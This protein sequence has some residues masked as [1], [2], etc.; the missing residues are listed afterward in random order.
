MNVIEFV[1]WDNLLSDIFLYQIFLTIPHPHTPRTIYS[2]GSAKFM[3]YFL[4][5]RPKKYNLSQSPD[6]ARNSN[7]IIR[8]TLKPPPPRRK[9]Q[10]DKGTRAVPLF[11]N[12]QGNQARHG[13]A[14]LQH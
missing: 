10:K 3:G 2:H 8:L 14:L 5:A 9:W 13:T 11:M 1:F 4:Q 6:S 12:E 7:N